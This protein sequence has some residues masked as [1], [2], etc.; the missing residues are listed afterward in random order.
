MAPPF[1]AQR[2]Y[3]QQSLPPP[4]AMSRLPALRAAS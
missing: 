2:I 1:T 3:A 4:P